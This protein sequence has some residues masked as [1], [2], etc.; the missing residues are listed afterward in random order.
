[1]ACGARDAVATSARRRRRRPRPRPTAAILR[2]GPAGPANR[3]CDGAGAPTPAQTRG[4]ATSFSRDGVR[5][6]RVL[7]ARGSSSRTSVDMFARPGPRNL[8]A[9]AHDLV[10]TG[11]QPDRCVLFV[12]EIDRGADAEEPLR[13]ESA[14]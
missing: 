10:H 14:Q 13:P 5:D 8:L 6:P 11:S 2:T 12:E 4:R 3:G 1:R 7:R 9:L